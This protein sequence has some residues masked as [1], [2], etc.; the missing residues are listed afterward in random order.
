[1][2][3]IELQRSVSVRIKPESWYSVK[4]IALCQKHFWH[5]IWQTLHCRHNESQLCLEGER[6]C[7][8]MGSD[9]AAHCGLYSCSALQ[10]WCISAHA[11]CETHKQRSH[12]TK[13]PK[14]LETD[15]STLL[16][17][18]I[19]KQHNYCIKLCCLEVIQT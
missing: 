14:S 16:Y 6:V 4:L 3:G 8:G 19:V 2:W 5:G 15:V 11:C 9:V 1:M 18:S 13:Q 12:T 10:H 7:S 17:H